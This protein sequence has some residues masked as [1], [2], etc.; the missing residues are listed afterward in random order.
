KYPDILED[1]K[2]GEAARQLFSDARELLDRIIE[3][4]LITARA[5]IGFWPAAR[6]GSDDIAVYADERRGQPIE[7][8]HHLRQQMNKPNDQPNFSLA[9]FVAPAESGVAD[10]VGAFVVT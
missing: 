6:V 5:V 7:T 1:S 4:K 2:V 8:L 9:D 10:Y 3:Q